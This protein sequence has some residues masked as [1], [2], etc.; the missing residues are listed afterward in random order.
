M[1][2]VNDTASFKQKERK[3]EERETAVRSISRVAVTRWSAC[4]ETRGKVAAGI[5][6]DCAEQRGSSSTCGMLAP[7]KE[8]KI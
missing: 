3:K 4:G 5:E 2:E 8:C 6:E 7:D 1:K